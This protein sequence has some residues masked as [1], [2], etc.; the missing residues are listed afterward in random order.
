MK[1][2]HLA[3]SLL[4]TILAF[5]TL[6]N[7]I[8]EQSAVPGG[9]VLVPLPD[10]PT[11]P[12][13]HFNKQRVM[14]IKQ[15]QKWL[16]VVG[17][18]LTLKP[19]E[20][21]LTV[22]TGTKV[23]K[24]AFDVADKQYESQHITLKNKRQVNP[25]KLDMTRIGQESKLIKNA[26]RQWRDATELPE[27]SL[28]VTG[29]LSSPFGLRRYFNE[30]ARKPHSGVDIAAPTGTPIVSPADGYVTRRGNYFFNGNTLFIDHGQ[31]LITMY[32]H[33]DE[34]HVNEGDHIKRGEQIGTIGKTGR[35]TGPHLHWGVSLNDARIDPSL[36]SPEL[37][38]LQNNTP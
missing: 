35:A 22:T 33:M 8:P 20:H 3:I 10:T 27:L 16:A 6:A 15:S 28:P 23:H 14:T 25:N 29:R 24:I 18:P 7:F 26:L 30:Q 4:L 32:C 12:T 31:G 17:I 1:I 9:L 13:A 37:K 5:P 11:T 34:I 2:N 38:K 36:L 19:G 21:H